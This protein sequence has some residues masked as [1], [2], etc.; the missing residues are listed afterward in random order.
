VFISRNSEKTLK[1][2]K[3]Q[4]KVRFYVDDY[5]LDELKNVEF[6]GDKV[7]FLVEGKVKISVDSTRTEIKFSSN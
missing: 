1:I 6:N 5:Y 3:L 2:V 7:G 4:N